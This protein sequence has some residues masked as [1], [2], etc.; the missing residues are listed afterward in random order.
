MVAHAEEFLYTA[1]AKKRDEATLESVVADVK[2]SG[3]F[4]TPTLSTYQ[5]VAQMWGRQQVVS[6]WLR[7]PQTRFVSP[8]VRLHWDRTF[9]VHRQPEDLSREL[10]FQR[11]FTLALQRAG[12]P[13]LAGTDSPEVPGMFPGTSIV[14]ELK[15]LLESG[16]SPFEALAM[17]TRNA[18]E[19]IHRAHP[20]TQPF[21]TIAEGARADI[22]LLSENPLTD[23]AA[24]DHIQGVMAAGTWFDFKRVSSLVAERAHRYEHMDEVQ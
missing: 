12:V 16:L 7:E 20:E 9:Y 6:T 2:R 21:G 8:T 22:L 13:L 4:V 15:N 23:L 17:A 10:A 18:G 14:T 1:F 19:F 11:R 3:S 5:A 24:F